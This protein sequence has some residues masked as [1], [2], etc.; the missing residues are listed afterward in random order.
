MDATTV[1]VD[2]AKDVFQVA[3]AN[4]AGRIIE[5]KRLTRRQFERFVD[6][7]AAGTEVIMEACGIVAT[8]GY[9]NANHLTTLVYTLSQTTLGSVTYTYDAVGNRTALSGSWAR[10]GLPQPLSSATYDAANR[11]QSWSGQLFSYDPNGNLTSDGL[12]SYSWNA[13]DQ[14]MGLSGATSATFQ[15]DGL[16]RRRSKTISGTTT[17]FLYDRW[18]FVQEQ[19]GGGMP[20]AN[21]L[22]GLGVDQIFT[23][24][25]GTGASSLLV[26]GLGS[27]LEIADA[28][29]TRQT[30]YT[31][32]AFGATTTSGATSTNAQAFTGRENDGTG[33]YFY[34]ARFYSP[35]LQRFISEDPAGFGASP[36]LFAYTGNRPTNRTDPSGMWDSPWHFFITEWAMIAQGSDPASAASMARKVADVDFRKGSFGPDPASA[37]THAMSGRKNDQQ[38]S[39]NQANESTKQQLADDLRD[40]DIPKLLHTI[41]DATAPGHAGYQPWHGGWWP[42]VETFLG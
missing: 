11:I 2:L 4:R 21:L 24:T 32:E 30:H 6:T 8:Y 10:T 36:N 34:R 3:L 28:S 19:T 7:L 9:D 39:C 37:N 40:D 18:N 25:D 29:G 26:D 33:L 1:A 35:G 41:Q 20:T 12:T 5:R 22:T 38:Q 16:R 31:F 23:R 15:Y 14:L 13:R 42:R 27:T 17:N